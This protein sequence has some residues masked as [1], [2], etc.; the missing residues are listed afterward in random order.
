MK[1]SLEVKNIYKRLDGFILSNISFDLKEGEIILVGG[2]NGA[3]KTKLLETISCISP[4]SKGYISYFGETVFKDK[5]LKNKLIKTNQRLGVQIQNERLF[6]SLTVEEIFETL[7]SLYGVEDYERYYSDCPHIKG[8][9]QKRVNTLSDGKKQLIKFLLSIGHD[10]D[11]IL[12]DEPTSYLDGDVRNWVF[13][14][15]KSL[16]SEGKSFIISLNQFWDIGDIA[17]RLIILKDG[18]IENIIHDFKD[19]YNGSAI[20]IQT[21]FKDG[22]ESVLKDIASSDSHVISRSEKKSIRIIT[23][24][25]IKTIKD[26]FDIEDKYIIRFSRPYLEDFYRLRGGYKY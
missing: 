13:N 5:I 21:I 18:Q 8:E 3:G 22:S 20:S 14:K 16:S 25:D 12:L 9:L 26:E 7:S 19:F 2:K 6:G 24:Y 23:K 4:P 17:D 15:V 1:P 10:P 11:I